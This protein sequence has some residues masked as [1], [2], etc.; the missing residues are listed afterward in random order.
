MATFKMTVI[1]EDAYT[2]RGRKVFKLETLDFAAALTR[3]GTFASALAGIM[4][5]K[6]LRYDVGQEVSYSDTV[7]ALSNKDEGATIQTDLG[8]GKT[9]S[10]KIPA[11]EK[12]IFNADGSVDLTDALVTALE[13]E[14]LSG[15]V[16][17]SDGEVVLDFKSGV[18]DK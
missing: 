2:R 11:P 7:T 4:G 15:E 1:Y 3:A 12:G 5:A 14:Y 8:A 10:L 17:I 6:I 16:T 13:S 9:A 18:L